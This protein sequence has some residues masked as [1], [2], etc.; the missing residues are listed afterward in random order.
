MFSSLFG[1]PPFRSLIG[2]GP[3][4]RAGLLCV[5]MVT[6]L[7]GKELRIITSM[8]P[9]LT[10]PF[11]ET[12][13]SQHPDIDILLL[14]KN[15][16]A[17][18][19][20]ILRGNPRRFDV[21]WA[22]SP[23]AFTL[24]ASRQNFMTNACPAAGPEGHISFAY[25][26]VGWTLRRGSTANMP[27]YW[28]DL[29]AAQY[30]GKIGMALP[31]RSGT[32]H[33]L[34]ERF[35]QV[36]GWDQGWTYFL[37]L[38]G[39]LATLGARSF[40]VIDGVRA[41][42]FDIGLTIDFLAKSNPDLDF[43]YGQPTMIF[44]AQIGLLADDSGAGCDFIE[45]VTSQQG[46]SLLLHPDIARTPALETAR[47]GAKP[48]PLEAAIQRQWQGYQAD[49]AQRRY[50]AV[51]T[52][53]EL[54][55]AEDLPRRRNLLTRLEALEGKVPPASIAKLRRRLTSLPV[56]ETQAMEAD[57]NIMPG[58]VSDLIEMTDPQKVAYAQ[59]RAQA[60]ALLSG[61]EFGIAQL[62]NPNR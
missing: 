17:A 5:L 47:V 12:F 38:S 22:S 31:S 25:S 7:H 14:N 59:W 43:R 56:S 26:S 13:K 55:I 48:D 4:I 52:I 60:Q 36:R 44:P 11:V 54:F 27:L 49:L 37:N 24:I 18:L 28:D 1:A 42:R 21:F 50:W 34:V 30:R 61:V 57:L 3:K 2:F 29:L 9:S 51:N 35:L 6:P 41:G 62:E 15:T 33:M 39:N 23:E 45:F 32:T 40:G 58:H 46:K 10:D 8:P 53:F 16:N 20:E 19:S